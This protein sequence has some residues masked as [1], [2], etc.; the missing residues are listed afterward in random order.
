MAAAVV[1]AP[2]PE[3]RRKEIASL[4]AGGVLRLRKLRLLNETA[5]ELQESS[6]NSAAQHLEFFGGTVLSVSRGNGSVSRK[7]R[8]K[9]C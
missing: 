2:S 5:E 3:D 4:L 9:T 6:A 8:S 7:P 1:C